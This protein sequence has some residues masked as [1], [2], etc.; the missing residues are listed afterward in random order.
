M[1][2]VFTSV[3]GYD[4]F[5][6]AVR[7][8]WRYFLDSEQK[9][10]LATVL[11]TAR[12]RQKPLKA[13]AA[14]WRAQTG[15]TWPSEAEEE[16]G[17]YEPRAFVPIRMK[18]PAFAAPDGRINVRGIPCLYLATNPE[19]AVAEQRPGNGEHV[20]VACLE[21]NHRV[22][23]LNCA[24][25]DSNVRLYLGGEPDEDAREGACWGAINRAF[26]Q[27]VERG[28]DAADYAPT[29]ILGEMFRREG[30][31]G[32]EYRSGLERSGHNIAL[33]DLSAADV[34]WAAVWSVD[35]I[36]V[37]SSQC[38][39]PYYVTPKSLVRNRIV[40]FLPVEKKKRK[41]RKK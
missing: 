33:F 40:A 6:A 7:R 2:Q 18:P 27:P 21:L 38:S 15:C 12:S 16:A 29:Q 25:D 17:D 8:D 11:A 39:N 41:P 34:K 3:H 31:D 5:A 9:K 1:S 4:R 36:Q 28:E 14:L 26:A 37:K 30:F 23:L 10:F 35:D 32:I 22:K 20:S 13:G 19:T 24:A